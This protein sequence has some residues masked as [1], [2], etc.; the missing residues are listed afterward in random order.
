M[1]EYRF[2]IY[3]LEHT[4]NTSSYPVIDVS[5]GGVGVIIAHPISAVLCKV[6][7][8][9]WCLVFYVFGEYHSNGSSQYKY[10]IEAIGH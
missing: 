7:S 1:H 3:V 6:Y 8:E 2:H 9:G 5:G 4:I 10:C